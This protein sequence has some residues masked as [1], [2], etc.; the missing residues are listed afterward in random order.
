MRAI[1]PRIPVRRA[2]YLQFYNIPVFDDNSKL[3]LSDLQGLYDLSVCL[4]LKSENQF[5]KYQKIMP[6]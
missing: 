6:K 4:L 1:A 2:V 3:D 5:L